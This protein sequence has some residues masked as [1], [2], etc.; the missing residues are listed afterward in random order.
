MKNRNLLTTQILL[1]NMKIGW[2]FVV[3]TLSLLSGNIYVFSF[4]GVSVRFENYPSPII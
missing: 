1:N 2:F 4:T 3:F